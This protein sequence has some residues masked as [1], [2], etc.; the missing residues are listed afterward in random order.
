[1]KKFFDDIK[2]TERPL[3]GRVNNDTILLMVKWLW[4]KL[5]KS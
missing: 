5:K 2:S 4:L 1:M 3:N